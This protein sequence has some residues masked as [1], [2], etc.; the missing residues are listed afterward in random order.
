MAT[1]IFIFL[2]SCVLTVIR[3]TT[4]C[5]PCI[6]EHLLRAPAFGIDLSSNSVSCAV[7]YSNG[8]INDITRIMP[9]N[10][11]QQLFSR[12]RAYSHGGALIS[13]SPHLGEGAFLRLSRVL[14]SFV[15]FILPLIHSTPTIPL[16]PGHKMM[17]ID[18]EVVY[19]A[20]QQLLDAAALA[21]TL[22]KIEYIGLSVPRA[23]LSIKCLSVSARMAAVAYGIGLCE[24]YADSR[25]CY[26]E[27]EKIPLETVLVLEYNSVALTGSLQYP[28]GIPNWVISAVSKFN[29]F[30]DDMLGASNST[31]EYNS[32]YWQ[33]VTARIADFVRTQEQNFTRLIILG[34]AAGEPNFHQALRDALSTFSYIAEQIVDPIFTGQDPGT[35]GAAEFA[36]RG[37]AAQQFLCI[38]PYECREPRDK[39]DAEIAASTGKSI[40]N[41]NQ[42]EL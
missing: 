38:E 3:A 29:Y 18:T 25:H 33:E 32:S 28:G 35:R 41:S 24:H 17:D 12:F 16:P 37:M 5:V 1:T 27:V 8:T 11:Y 13:P 36:K 42:K 10:D 6:P 7:R 21:G 31:A 4:F 39:I 20:I 40:S 9:N 23:N 14:R 2:L 26:F 22:S 34:E 19:E 30:T 15:L